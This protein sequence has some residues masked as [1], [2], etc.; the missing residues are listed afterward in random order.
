MKWFTD[1]EVGDERCLREWSGARFL[2]GL[3]TRLGPVAL[4]GDP[5][6]RLVVLDDLGTHASLADRLLGNDPDAAEAALLDVFAALGRLNATTA[7]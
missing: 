5:E 3:S 4:G 7:G 2:S 1:E 6:L